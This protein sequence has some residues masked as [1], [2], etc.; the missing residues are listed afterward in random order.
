[1]MLNGAAGCCA[2]KPVMTCDVASDAAD[3]STL[4]ATLGA[5]DCREG[6]DRRSEC[7]RDEKF[8]HIDPCISAG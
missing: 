4:K 8:A 1:M 2:D 5:G 3:R 6:C 7:Q